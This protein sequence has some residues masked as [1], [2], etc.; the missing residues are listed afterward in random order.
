VDFSGKAVLVTGGAGFVGSN[1]AD[2]LAS[3]GARVTVIDNLSTGFRQFVSDG[4]RLVEGDLL[5]TRA[6]DEAMRGQELVFHLAANADVRDGTK[7]PRRDVEQN[8]IATHNVLEAMR[9][10]GVKDI[11][12]SS[13]GSIYGE[14]D[15]I[16]T[17]E[18]CP[19]P[20]QTSLYGASKVG[21]EGLLTA[22]AS[23]FGLQVWIFRFVSLLGPRY[24]HGH[25]LDFWRKLREDPTRLYVLG[26]GTQK[27]SYLHINDCIEA[28]FT[29]IARSQSKTGVHV[30]NLG[31]EEWIEVNQSIRII[32][33][34]LGVSPKLEY[35]GGPR[36]WVGDSPRILLETKRIRALGW[37]PTQTIAE[38]IVDTLRFLQANPFVAERR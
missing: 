24:S 4:I 11:A 37:K 36:G 20:V 18:D 10:H 23:G 14:P 22:Y 31:H 28:M 7:H 12:F 9:A 34:E 8:L 3:A 25:V 2:R 29:A 13:T 1:V 15:V 33:G 32:C 17:P 38:A 21:A 26:D 16:P 6:L 27:K 30:Y 35:A 19:F 5:D